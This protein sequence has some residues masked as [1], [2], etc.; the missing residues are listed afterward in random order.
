M[1]KH[2]VNKRRK[3]L[4]NNL[5]KDYSKDLVYKMLEELNIKSTTRSEELDITDFIK[6]SDY[7]VENRG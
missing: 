7:I 6:M 5:S 4:V 1:W 3:T 2:F